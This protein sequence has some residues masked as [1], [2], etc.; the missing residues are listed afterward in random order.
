[1]DLDRLAVRNLRQVQALR[2]E[3]ETAELVPHPFRDDQGDEPM[4]DTCE[5]CRFAP[6]FRQDQRTS[7]DCLRYP[8]KPGAMREWPGVKRGDWCGEWSGRGAVSAKPSNPSFAHGRTRAAVV[9]RSKSRLV[10]P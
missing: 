9:E 5:T 6:H 7:A 8:P 3:P 10:G 2:A 4:S 1:M